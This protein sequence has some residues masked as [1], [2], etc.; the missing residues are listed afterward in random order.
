MDPAIA[1]VALA[2]SLISLGWQAWTWARGGPILKVEVSNAVTDVGL[3]TGE[4]EHFVCVTAINTG[5]SALTVDTWGIELPDGRSIFAT[6]P[7]D[8]SGPPKARLEPG[9][10]VDYYIHADDVRGHAS[11][12]RVRFDDMRPWVRTAAGVKRYSKK[13][14]PLE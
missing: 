10:S 8:F 11:L 13:P 6:R 5:G 9:E 1:L 4:P 14:V 7:D 3:F 12:N 2:L